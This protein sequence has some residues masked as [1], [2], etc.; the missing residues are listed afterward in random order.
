MFD[1]ALH[2]ANM[3]QYIIYPRVYKV[4]MVQCTICVMVRVFVYTVLCMPKQYTMSLCLIQ[5]LGQDSMFSSVLL[6]AM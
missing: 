6:R 5:R 3:Q 2:I 1:A 4:R